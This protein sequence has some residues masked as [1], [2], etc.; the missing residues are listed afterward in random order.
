[1]RQNT[2]CIFGALTVLLLL[3]TASSDRR[4]HEAPAG[5]DSNTNGFTSQTTFDADLDVFAE[6]EEVADGLGPVF[7]ERG[8]AT[9]HS[10]PVVGGSSNTVRELRAGHYD[11]ERRKF[12]DH[13]GGSLIHAFTICE[14]LAAL[15]DVDITKSQCTKELQEK[16]L[17]GYEVQT[18]RASNSVLGDG[19]VEAI[20]DD[21]LRDIA[22]DQ[23]AKSDGRVRGQVISVP[24]LEAGGALRVGRFGWKNQHASLV[25]FAA[26]AYLNE[27]G[28]TSPLQPTEN[29]S[30]GRSVEAYD[31]VPDPEDNG[32]DIESFASFMRA[33]KVPPRNTA[34]ADTADAQAGEFLFNK[35]GCA[36]C[37]VPTIVTAPPGTPINGGKFRVP[38]A[39]GNKRIHPYSDFLLH[40]IGTGDGIVQNGGRSTR[41]KVRTAPLWGLRTRKLLMH[42]GESTTPREAIQRHRGEAEDVIAEYEE[43]SDAQQHQILTFLKSL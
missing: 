2:L 23:R 25:S 42:D 7:N 15:P 3:G 4:Q 14:D 24:V 8:C 11:K 28:I 33:T 43:L 30:N 27:M 12:I 1:M 37:H 31:R 38:E 17:P 39:L 16:I 21:T 5:F 41:N 20:A 40:N 26:D 6:E 36:L 35:I 18:F 34:L 22:S 9:C 29:T 13:P 32:E 10:V 19:Y